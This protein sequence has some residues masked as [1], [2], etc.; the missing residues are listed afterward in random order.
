M[1][2]EIY[3]FPQLNTHHAYSP[4]AF[5]QYEFNSEGVDDLVIIYMVNQPHLQ[6][7]LIP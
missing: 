4:G 3:A 1:K 2:Q 5:W 6:S 7:V